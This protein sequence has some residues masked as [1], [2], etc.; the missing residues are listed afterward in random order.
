MTDPNRHRPAAEVD[1]ESVTPELLARYDRPGP[2]YTSYPTAPQFTQDFGEPDYAAALG[3]AA[4][5]ADQP[6][7]MYVHVPFCDARCTY[8]GCSV[9]ISP[10]RGP[11]QR[12]LAAVD[13]E[14]ELVAAALG[15]RRTL[16]QL[17]WGGGT[18]TYLTP[19]QLGTLFA[20]IRE[21]FSLTP[22]AE[23]AV[24]VDPCGRTTRQRNRS[25][26]RQ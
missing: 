26:A 11:E 21:R 3:R 13:R 8:C 15:D 12:Y 7:S 6:L 4:A 2:R 16:S 19:A 20:S 10:H 25:S 9:V 24:E 14:L 22:D 5:A 23:I 18:P 1:F 17:H